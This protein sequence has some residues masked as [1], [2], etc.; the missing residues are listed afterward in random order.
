MLTIIHL[1]TSR[2]DRLIWLLEELGHEYE[3]QTF[4]RDP[5]T[6]RSPAE[7]KA[8]HPYAKAP[9]LRDGDRVLIESGAIFEYVMGRYGDAGLVPKPEDADWP[10]YLQWF[11]FAEGSAMLP[12]LLDHFQA[13]GL[14]GPPGESGLAAMARSGMDQLYAYIESVLSERTWLA[15]DRFTAADVMM[16][17]VVEVV[18]SRGEIGPYPEMQ[19][20]VAAM[21][22]R[23]AYQ[24]AMARARGE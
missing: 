4:E 17:W 10:D 8:L 13:A 7:M 12:I 11:H 24:R 14:A 6:Q 15:G 20:Y 21:R 3:I 18:E 1:E 22:A 5:E 19:R 23:P 16:G 9:M 2:S